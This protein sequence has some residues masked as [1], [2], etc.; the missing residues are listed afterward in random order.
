M[1]K[2]ENKYELLKLPQ[3]SLG[4]IPSDFHNFPKLNNCLTGKR[5]KSKVKVIATDDGYYVELP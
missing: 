2:L 1:E 4:M 5:F 3:N